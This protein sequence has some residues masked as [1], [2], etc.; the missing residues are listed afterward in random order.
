MAEGNAVFGISD[1]MLTVRGDT[2]FESGATKVFTFHPANVICLSA[3]DANS[4]LEIARETESRAKANGTTDV[5]GVASLFAECHAA[6]RRKR[7]EE[8]YLAPLGLDLATFL[9]K[10]K[11][12]AP[13]L[14][15]RL[16]AQMQDPAGDLNAEA[17][18]AGVDATGAHIYHVGSP[19][20]SRCCDGP[21]FVAIGSG[22][23]H[24]ETVFMAQSYGPARPYNDALLLMVS[25]KRQA[26][27][28]PGVG[29]A[30]DV[31]F[32]GNEGSH[33][34]LQDDVEAIASCHDNLARSMAQARESI[35][36][37]MTWDYM[38]LKPVREPGP[39]APA[40]SLDPLRGCL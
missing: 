17:I 21:G 34:L 20:Q 38:T 14:V 35:V 8:C 22:A 24:F 10:Q 9:S 29:R 36:R 27:M 28:A 1:R 30:T 6:H 3:G 23:R 13:G 33:A 39:V 12:M 40:E 32:M 16:V 7:L 18:I 19:G 37:A 25:A 5:S 11:E 26:E 4:S 15:K 2:E 31:I